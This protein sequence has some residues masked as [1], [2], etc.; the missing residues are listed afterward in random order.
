MIHNK[1]ASERYHKEIEEKTNINFN[2]ISWGNDAAD[3]I[4]NEE[5]KILVWMP[6]KSEGFTHFAIARAYDVS[7]YLLEKG[8]LRQVINWINDNK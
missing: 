5:L 2:D 6:N 7:E 3:S 1:K 8:T 4:E